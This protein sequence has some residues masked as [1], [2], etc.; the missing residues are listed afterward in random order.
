[1]MPASEAMTPRS[2]RRV[3]FSVR[4]RAP[5]S[6]VKMEEVEV[7]MVAEATVVYFKQAMAK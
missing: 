5:M 3:N 2:L 6:R 1:M 7:R 4:V